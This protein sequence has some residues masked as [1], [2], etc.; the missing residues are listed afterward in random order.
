MGFF[1]HTTG[2]RAQYLQRQRVGMHGSCRELPE[3]PDYSWIVSF[4]GRTIPS[5]IWNSSR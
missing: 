5:M 2:A 3:T 4:S 1:S